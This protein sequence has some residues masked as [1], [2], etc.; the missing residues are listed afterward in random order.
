[1]EKDP[2][3]TKMVDGIFHLYLRN[4][5][6]TQP[7]QLCA[8][9]HLTDSKGAPQAVFVALS[10]LGKDKSGPDF[11]ENTSCFKIEPAW[12]AFQEIPFDLHL[13]VES[14][15]IPLSGSINL[16]SNAISKEPSAPQLVEQKA[17]SLHDCA[18]SSKL[19]TRP[20]MLLPSISPSWLELPLIGAPTIAFGYLVI[21]LVVLRKSLR[22]PVRAPQWNFATSFASNF[23]IGT[24]LLTPLLGATVTTDALHYM[25]K[26]H[27]TVLSILFAA[28]LI[29]APAIFW[30]FS[31]PQEIP[32]PT[33][34]T[35]TVSVG[36]IR[37][38]LATAALMICAVLGQLIT[39]GLA[40][41]EVQFRGYIAYAPLTV[42]LCL[43][44]VAGTGT[45]VSAAKTGSYLGQESESVAPTSDHLQ[46]VGKKVMSI[47]PGKA[48]GSA[49]SDQFTPLE[50]Q[51]FEHLMGE[52]KTELRAWRMF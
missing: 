35:S 22:K 43:L 26:A 10:S 18:S 52:S 7:D 23:T 21:Y 27:Y 30:F 20:V 33:G 31:S 46:S 49:R 15:F 32:T 25:T 3:N 2:G 50:Q 48:F 16:N 24:G 4:E 42:M 13:Q 9:A 5:G 34:Q 29:L 1:M 38:F 8:S 12:K 6:P 41:A 40:I 17:E 11:K 45:I 28:L 37:L 39:V 36:S 51:T 44:L 19:L 47:S 14:P